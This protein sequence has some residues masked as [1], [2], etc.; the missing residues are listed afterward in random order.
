MIIKIIST[1]IFVIV[2]TILL[3]FVNNKSNFS[4]Y[5]IIPVI[6]SLI[7]KYVMGDYDIGFVWSKLDIVYWISVL[8]VSYITLRVLEK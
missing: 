3:S 5:Y 2:V 6:V 4:S 8:G 1:L 7:T